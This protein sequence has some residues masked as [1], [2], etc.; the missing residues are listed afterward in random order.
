MS[1]QGEGDATIDVTALRREVMDEIA[2]E[3]VNLSLIDRH[4]D[5]AKRLVPLVIGVLALNAILLALLPNYPIYWIVT[6]FLIYMF[7]F[8]VL[9][10]PTTRRLRTP[11]EKKEGLRAAPWPRIGRGIRGIVLHGKKAVTVA[12]WNAFF[13]GTEVMAKGITMIMAVSIALVLLVFAAGILDLYSAAII[14]V[15]AITIMGYYYVIHRY[16]PYTKGFLRSVGRVR[17][18]GTGLRWQTYPRSVLAVLMVLMVF[19]VFL[20]GGVLLPGQSLQAFLDRLD[21]DL[22]L[23]LI[24]SIVV[25]ISQ[26]IMVR[27]VQGFDSARLAAGFIKDKLSF[28]RQDVLAGIEAAEQLGNDADRSERLSGLHKKFRASRIYKVAYKDIF[29]ILPTYPLI[30]DLKAILEEEVVEAL[31]EEGIPIDM[32]AGEPPSEGWGGPIG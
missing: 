10:V 8:I 4:G 16:R 14:A 12:F 13:I 28:L 1:G 5:R 31:T 26:F 24:G 32:P 18:K 6:G 2:L 30:V 27:Y 11:A 3:E 21:D 29:G 7:Y 22:A 19:A 23:T 20:I 15:Q 9:M 17:T 25:F